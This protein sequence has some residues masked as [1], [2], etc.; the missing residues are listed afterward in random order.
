[1]PRQQSALCVL[2]FCQQ[3][4]HKTC[5]LATCACF[6]I[7]IAAQYVNEFCAWHDQWS[8]TTHSRW[9]HELLF[10]SQSTQQFG[11][12]HITNNSTPIWLSDFIYGNPSAC[13]Y[14]TKSHIK[15]LPFSSTKLISNT[16]SLYKMW[17]RIITIYYIIWDTAN[18]IEYLKY[19]LMFFFKRDM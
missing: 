10:D 13:C 7:R 1:M 6:Y 19:C 17:L 14:L 18:G 15:S 12:Y 16:S 4:H 2:L 5:Y 3:S 8:H 11:K 9:Y